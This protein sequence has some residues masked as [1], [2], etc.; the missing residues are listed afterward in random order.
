MIKTYAKKIIVFDIEDEDEHMKDK[1]ELALIHLDNTIGAFPEVIGKSAVVRFIDLSQSNYNDEDK[2]S[3][4][5]KLIKKVVSVLESY[6]IKYRI[7]T[8]KAK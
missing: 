4:L 8:I 6:Q 7:C 2:E 3:L 5:E 1:K